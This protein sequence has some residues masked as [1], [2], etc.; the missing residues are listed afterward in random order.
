LFEFSNFS[1][2]VVCTISITELGTVEVTRA[3]SLPTRIPLRLGPPLLFS[4]PQHAA[5]NA[6]SEFALKAAGGYCAPTVI[7]TA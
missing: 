2:C 1:A 4:R 6:F 7:V 5:D 3:G